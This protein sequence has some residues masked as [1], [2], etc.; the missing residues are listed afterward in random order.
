MN[1]LRQEMQQLLQQ[2][3]DAAALPEPESV[4][5][6]KVMGKQVEDMKAHAFR[7]TGYY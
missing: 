6:E 3:E 7:H 5:M 1:S 2:Q 4:R